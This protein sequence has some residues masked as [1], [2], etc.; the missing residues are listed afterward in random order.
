LVRISTLRVPI[1]LGATIDGESWDLGPD[2]AVGL[3]VCGV[4]PVY[5]E[6]VSIA[7]SKTDDDNEVHYLMVPEIILEELADTV[8]DAR[9]PF[10]R[11]MISQHTL[12]ASAFGSGQVLESMARNCLRLRFSEELGQGAKLK[13]DQALPFFTATLLA[14]HSASVAEPCFLR[15]PKISKHPKPGKSAEEIATFWSET[16]TFAELHPEDKKALVSVLRPAT[17]YEPVLKSAS[18]DLILFTAEGGIAEIQL[19]DGK[20]KADQAMLAK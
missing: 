16:P 9:L 6:R 11:A 18:G 17:I 19:K 1:N 2:V 13:L 7:E 8:Q 4:F 12:Q 14:N 15:F 20:Q 3:Q 10:W 5:L